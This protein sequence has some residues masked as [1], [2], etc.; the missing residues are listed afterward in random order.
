MAKRIR[1]ER[2]DLSLNQQLCLANTRV[3]STLGTGNSSTV[4]LAE[5]I[6]LNVYRAIKCIPK[7][8]S[9]VSFTFFGSHTSEES[10][11]SWNSHYLRY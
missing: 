10:Q 4:Y 7:D 8:T 5:H 3:L 11:S 2:S 6:R 9:L 1:F